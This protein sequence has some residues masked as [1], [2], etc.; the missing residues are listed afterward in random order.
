MT[1]KHTSP[2]GAQ[3]EMT[4]DEILRLANLVRGEL[5]AGDRVSAMRLIESAIGQPIPLPLLDLL[6]QTIAQPTIQAAPGV[7]LSLLDGITD[8]QTPAAWAIVGSRS[9]ISSAMTEI[10][11]SSSI[12]VN[13]AR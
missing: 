13:A 6:G 1:T 7:F 12:S 4:Q 8:N 2:G 5:L 9:A 11:T 3:G 10:T